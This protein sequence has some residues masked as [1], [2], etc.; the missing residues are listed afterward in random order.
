MIATNDVYQILLQIVTSS[1]NR[2]VSYFV[3]GMHKDVSTT[4][5]PLS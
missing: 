5:P 4:P 3:E 2:I 1:R